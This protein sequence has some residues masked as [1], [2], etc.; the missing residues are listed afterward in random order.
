MSCRF[1]YGMRAAAIFAPFLALATALPLAATAQVEL[2][3]E[4]FTLDNGLRVVVH[5]DRKA[6]IV[7][8]SVWYHVGSKDEQP[9]KTGFAHLFEHLMFNGT[10]NYN[11]EYFKPFEQVGATGMNGTTWFDRTNY[12]ET[13]PTPALEMALWMES[14]RMGHLLGAIDQNKLDEQRGV[15]QNEKRQGDN[16]PYGRTEYRVLAG[17]FPEGHPYRWSPIG[18]MADLNAA[19]LDDVRE[20]F[21]TYYGTAN[22]VLVLAGDIDAASARPLIEK[23]FADIPAGPPLSRLQAAVPD[24]PHDV[25]ETMYDRV[26]Q[27]RILRYWAVPGRS[28]P[29]AALLSLAAQVLGGSKTSLLYHE[30]VEKTQLATQV[31]AS[32]ESHELASQ[33]AIDVLLKPGSDERQVNDTIDAVLERF[34]DR[35]PERDALRRA[36]TGVEA[37]FI[38]GL[39]VVG[40]FRGKASILAEGLLYAGDPAFYPQ[41]WLG[42]IVQADPKGVQRTARRWLD[43]PQYRL[44]VRPF[45]EYRTAAAGADRS[46][47]PETGEMPDLTFPEIE[48][49]RLSN[50]IEVLFARRT[51]VPVV[52]IAALFDAGYAADDVERSGL[53]GFAMAMLD[54]GTTTLSGRELAMRAEALGAVIASGSSLDTSSIT[55]SAL[56]DHLGPSLDLFADVA[57]HPAFNPEDLERERGILLARIEQE[58][59]SP[60]SSALRLL[61][62]LLYGAGHPY[63]IPLTGSGTVAA[64]QSFSRDDLIAFHRRWI[65]PDLATLF[66]AGDTTLAELLPLLESRFGDWEIPAAPPPVKRFSHPAPAAGNTLYLLDKPDS[67]QSLILAGQLSTPSGGDEEIAIDTMNEIIGGSFTSRINMNLREEKSWAYGAYTFLLDAKNERPLLIYAPVQTDRSGD[68]IA[69]IKR[70]LDE[71]LTTRPATGDELVKVV[72]NNVNSLPGRFETAQAVL[73]AMQ[74]NRLYGR[75]DDYVTT[76]AERYRRLDLATVR[77]TAAAT[78]K[79]AE[80]VWVVIGDAAK[81]APQL[82]GAGFTEIIRIDAEGRALDKGQ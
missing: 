72:N 9:G 65:R 45:P 73:G 82:T 7:A 48:R 53:A 76:L 15:V 55:L 80:L 33:F 77:Q 10:E 64:V 75:P 44:A 59:S 20:W 14:D 51:A 6:P 32:V 16:Q 81:I 38:R 27:T 26:A 24:L 29:D 8:L 39:E 1:N 58:K 23:Y 42:W 79:P 19:S 36:Q 28:T 22:A 31:S 60:V 25:N 37:S 2:P 46:R 74:S 35:G 40:G 56:Q 69:E 49:A 63:A 41:T 68:S 78:L 70:E 11:D 57:R 47:L 52:Q 67:P 61:P 62:P 17:L 4:Q 13:V 12:F 71:Y 21:K 5:E 43:R 54:E 18:S 30:L 3:F 66:A 50:G 34:L